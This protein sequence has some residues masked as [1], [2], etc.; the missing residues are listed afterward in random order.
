[1]LSYKILH[2]IQH[3]WISGLYDIKKIK[4]SL[5]INLTLKHFVERWDKKVT[6]YKT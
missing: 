6:T 3:E 5:L 2:E 1:M 4:T